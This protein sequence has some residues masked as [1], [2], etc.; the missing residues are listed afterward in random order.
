MYETLSSEA[1]RPRQC[2]PLACVKYIRNQSS[3]VPAP[4]SGATVCHNELMWSAAGPT[5]DTQ[6]HSCSSHSLPQT[7]P[8]F[9]SN[10]S[11]SAV[12]SHDSWSVS[13]QRART[14]RVQQSPT[15]PTLPTLSAL[16]HSQCRT[17]DVSPTV[18]PTVGLASAVWRPMGATL[19]Q[20]SERRAIDTT[21]PSFVAEQLR[22]LQ[23]HY[24]LTVSFNKEFSQHMNTIIAVMHD[25]CRV[26]S[27]P[28]FQYAIDRLRLLRSNYCQLTQVCCKYGEYQKNVRSNQNVTLPTVGCLHSSIQI[29]MNSLNAVMTIFHEMC[30][31]LSTD[32]RMT[33]TERGLGLSN[34]VCHFFPVFVRE[35]SNFKKS[36][37]MIVPNT[38]SA[39]STRTECEAPNMLSSLLG[40][41]ELSTAAVGTV[42]NSASPAAAQLQDSENVE[43]NGNNVEPNF[44]AVM[45]IVIEPDGVADDEVGLVQVKQEPVEVNRRR[46]KTH[47][48]LIYVDDDDDDDDGA[49]A[50]DGCHD[51]ASHQI[52]VDGS[53]RLDDR[54]NVSSS[55]HHSNSSVDSR[56][57]T[58][59][60]HETSSSAANDVVSTAAVHV[61]TSDN[62]DA[63]NE[64]IDSNLHDNVNDTSDVHAVMSDM[65]AS[66]VGVAPAVKST[67][68]D[69]TSAACSISGLQTHLSP[70]SSTSA[71]TAVDNAQDLLSSS[72][73]GSSAEDCARC[74]SV[75]ACTST[76][77]VT[78]SVSGITAKT[79][80][81]HDSEPH[82]V[83][84]ELHDSNI[85]RRE[86]ARSDTSISLSHV[87][88]L[89][90]ISSVCSVQLERFEFINVTEHATVD[91]IVTAVHA[92]DRNANVVFDNV[93]PGSRGL[94]PQ[95]SKQ[96]HSVSVKTARKKKKRVPLS[97]FARRRKRRQ[98]SKA[99]RS[100]GSK[101]C[102]GKDN[103]VSDNLEAVENDVSD[104]S[105]HEET[106]HST[107]D[108]NTVDNSTMTVEPVD[109]SK[110]QFQS[111]VI[112]C[113]NTDTEE[114]WPNSAVDGSSQPLCHD[115]A[116][117][118]E[119]IV[120]VPETDL[121]VNIDSLPE[122][123]SEPSISMSNEA[124]V[125]TNDVDSSSCGMESEK[126]DSS[127]RHPVVIVEQKCSEQSEIERT[128]EA[129]LL[130]N[131]TVKVRG[132]KKPSRV[133]K[134]V[135]S[136]H[137]V[138][139]T[140][141]SVNGES[142][143]CKTATS[144]QA[145]D[146]KK[147]T[148]FRSSN[149]KSASHKLTKKE[150]LEEKQ[151][152]KKEKKQE[153]CKQKQY[154]E[155]GKVAVEKP[156]TTV[157]SRART[158]QEHNRT[159][160]RQH[161]L[162]K[163]RKLLKR[164]VKQNTLHVMN[165]T[166]A[167]KN[168]SSHVNAATA[169]ERIQQRMSGR[170]RS[171]PTVVVNATEK[172]SY[173]D[174]NT[175]AVSSAS[176]VHSCGN[177]DH[178]RLSARD[179]VNA[180]FKNSEFTRLQS[181]TSLVH[182]RN[183]PTVPACSLP[184]SKV[185]NSP[186]K[187]DA[188][189]HVPLAKNSKIS[190]LDSQHNIPKSVF[191]SGSSAVTSS[192]V[193]STYKPVIRRPGGQSTSLITS[194]GIAHSDT[195]LK[196]KDRQT[197]HI[198]TSQM[199]QRKV[200]AG[201]VPAASKVV[202]SSG[203]GQNVQNSV[204][205]SVSKVTTC[206]VSSASCSITGS[207]PLNVP[208]AAARRD[209]RLA[210][211]PASCE[212]QRTFSLNKHNS[213]ENL[214][215]GTAGVSS[216]QNCSGSVQWPWEQTDNV[217]VPTT[218]STN[219]ESEVDTRNE[220]SA[221]HRGKAGCWVW[222]SENTDTSSSH[223][224]LLSV[225]V[226]DILSGL[227][228]SCS[229]A[230]YLQSTNENNQW[231]SASRVVHN[232]SL[233][234]PSFSTANNGLNTTVT[235]THKSIDKRKTENRRAMREDFAVPHVEKSAVAVHSNAN[236]TVILSEYSSDNKG[237][238][239]SEKVHNDIMSPADDDDS[240]MFA[241]NT[242][243][244]EQH[245][246]AENAHAPESLSPRSKYP[247]LILL[248]SSPV[249]HVYNS[250]TKLLS[251]RTISSGRPSDPRLRTTGL[252]FNSSSRTDESDVSRSVNQTNSVGSQSVVGDLMSGMQQPKP[253]RELDGLK[254]KT[255]PT[256]NSLDNRI[257]MF[258]SHMDTFSVDKNIE[259]HVEKMMSQW[260]ADSDGAAILL[261][262]SGD[263]QQHVEDNDSDV[264]DF[265]IIDS[266]DDDDDESS[267]EL[268]IDLDSGDTE[269]KAEPGLNQSVDDRRPFSKTVSVD[270]VKCDVTRNMEQIMST[271]SSVDNSLFQRQEH[272]ISTS[273]GSSLVGHQNKSVKLRN[274]KSEEVQSSKAE[275]HGTEAVSES[276][277][278][279]NAD[280]RQYVMKMTAPTSQSS[281]TTSA[282][283]PNS[284]E[285]SN[286]AANR[287][288][289]GNNS[290]PHATAFPKS[291]HK[292]HASFNMA[293]QNLET[294]A[295]KDFAEPHSTDHNSHASA[296]ATCFDSTSTVSACLACLADVSEPEL[297]VLKLQMEAKVKAVEH[298]ITKSKKY[299]CPLNDLNESEKQQLISDDLADRAVVSEFTTELRLQSL[300]R[301][302]DKTK[303]VM[304]KM[305]SQFDPTCP[306]LSLEKK[307]DQN[308]LAYNNLVVRRDWFY[309]RMNRLCRYHKSKC[310]LTLPDDLRFSAE[311]CKCV[312]VEGVPLILNNFT[313]P[314]HHCTRLAALLTLIRRLRSSPPTPM[315]RDLL[316]K[317][318]W[319]HQERK[320]LLS[321]ICC[322]SPQTVDDTVE[323]FSEKLTLYE[324]V[325]FSGIV[326][327]EIVV[328]QLRVYVQSV[329]SRSL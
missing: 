174:K 322:S 157:A 275:R 43:L 192:A 267:V 133:F 93:D 72:M 116:P 286:A 79:N 59:Q 189:S 17:A 210:Q 87:D 4:L 196:M 6:I 297:R 92:F 200:G 147:V 300:Q 86:S 229:A 110:K 285:N 238:R 315:P 225:D 135:D 139:P 327:I 89:C 142:M 48:G 251:E 73:S 119:S 261:D 108:E 220:R 241:D 160:I 98:Q 107:H 252:V 191:T 65:P 270:T 305:K 152:K 167:H 31:W 114:T 126:Q 58:S 118:S 272:S 296:S 40:H 309:M 70:S 257:D 56:P 248:D 283:E 208:S 159:A 103:S 67:A 268:V 236:R 46:Q 52:D 111:P 71:I 30:Q 185:T 316:L 329:I 77:S 130:T 41:V 51:V 260:K 125:D 188:R 199:S 5:S 228:T 19:Q 45:P 288:I 57:T 12:F 324:Y 61:H 145:N 3:V 168:V 16:Q 75:I 276:S 34:K 82:A 317:L 314:L 320:T 306:S 269:L 128:G 97:R 308:E 214:A 301:E 195:S 295:K 39:Q 122:R 183:K 26:V 169:N 141:T 224:S 161:K 256:A 74:T 187:V 318:G 319:L 64:C 80:V 140:S 217:A 113:Q 44:I 231:H 264:E 216:A 304:A 282:F 47:S 8:S 298:K 205:S 212:E 105:S 325:T 104:N 184:S 273:H 137:Q 204:P 323:L 115:A 206:V 49:G 178:P 290:E 13:D 232:G 18:M 109:S 165:G 255:L 90:T 209:P 239:S 265:I 28:V 321:D 175:T 91:D 153:G 246:S 213:A 215:P 281:N 313:I 193:H 292:F 233:V 146:A 136:E 176:I 127:E 245:C 218:G 123:Q 166:K 303:A 101:M 198:E 23:V 171:S 154:E 221:E 259:N 262:N 94:H 1:S 117:C 55:Q 307:Y 312:S 279:C 291:T 207:Q 197:N 102:T 201:K 106:L 129:E 53:L 266:D 96:S 85:L 280:T 287:E 326:I 148:K 263:T 81:M 29:M 11:V 144:V 156:F 25:A 222:Q 32:S 42:S 20:A 247:Q 138:S 258:V 253:L 76:A 84:D 112:T 22:L 124:A 88:N 294:V 230:E 37:L 277:S 163:S 227:S 21:Q 172:T 219:V 177:E 7:G 38:E 69:C 36:L 328:Q 226:G 151:S 271:E 243:I 293:E 274:G 62:S 194:T 14:S 181:N 180:I 302:I 235:K 242:S 254:S 223:S 24:S 182:S 250:S 278:E 100:V 149:A 158:V 120:D 237:K 284:D 170:L 54:L 121:A 289:Y 83:S 202:C 244:I 211:R 162:M 50:V 27:S 310:L 9:P 99:L 203:V 155:S 132:K 186:S 190:H 249:L 33:V 240:Q 78:D 143:Q 179:K 150:V 134:E 2:V 68:A 173:T 66:A 234:S 311:S 35:M 63:V 10:F 164:G 15:L 299:A 95:K 60:P 131:N